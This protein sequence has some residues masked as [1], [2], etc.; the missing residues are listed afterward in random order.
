MS[1]GRPASTLILV[2]DGSTQRDKAGPK[3]AVPPVVVPDRVVAAVLVVVVV[4]GERGA[5]VVPPV[6]PASLVNRDM[7]AVVSQDKEVP[8]DSAAL[9]GKVAVVLVVLAVLAV[10]LADRVAGE[11]A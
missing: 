9:A 10:E 7:E 4:L 6:N 8:V 11:V 3:V 1:C 5:A 2:V